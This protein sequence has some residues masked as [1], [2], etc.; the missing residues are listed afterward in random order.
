M[1]DLKPT[2]VEAENTAIEIDNRRWKYRRKL[3]FGAF[4]LAAGVIAAIVA[5]VLFGDLE[6]I[7]ALG[8][9]GALMLAVFGFLG[10]IIMAYVGSATYSD[11]KSM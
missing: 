5:V 4:Y 2:D 9:M 7:A 10:G 3:A 8:D 6:R 1:T 11:V